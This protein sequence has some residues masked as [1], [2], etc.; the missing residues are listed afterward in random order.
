MRFGCIVKYFSLL[1]LL[2]PHIHYF[3]ANTVFMFIK[4]KKAVNQ[5]FN[6]LNPRPVT[7][8]FTKASSMLGVLLFLFGGGFSHALKAQKA[9]VAKVAAEILVSLDQAQ[10]MRELVS[11]KQTMESRVTEAKKNQLANLDP[12][13]LQ[14]FSNQYNAVALSF[15]ELLQALKQDVLSF[16]RKPDLNALSKKYQ[17]KIDNLRT[18]VDT[19]TQINLNG[20]A[21]DMLGNPP[22][23]WGQII[24]IV[25]S[26]VPSIIQSIQKNKKLNQ[27]DLV[28][29]INAL[30]PDFLQKYKMLGFEA[31]WPEA[32][33]FLRKQSSGNSTTERVAPSLLPSVGNAKVNVLV[34]EPYVL[35]PL[36]GDFRFTDRLP[37]GSEVEIP[38][39]IQQETKSQTI[40]TSA[41]VVIGDTYRLQLSS[42]QPFVYVFSRQMATGN[43]TLHF[44]K[45]ASVNPVSPAVAPGNPKPSIS[46]SMNMR[47]KRQMLELTKDIDS[48][49]K[50]AV[51]IKDIIERSKADYY[52]Y[53]SAPADNPITFTWS[54]D[55]KP[56]DEQMI[57]LFSNSEIF[58]PVEFLRRYLQLP[59]G[60]TSG[61]VLPSLAFGQDFVAN[62]GSKNQDTLDKLLKA[63]IISIPKTR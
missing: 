58:F 10:A 47:T 56:G 2:I 55:D 61:K 40:L 11:L 20:I 6:S 36:K 30:T 49:D 44:P 33:A 25:I 59:S 48:K 53:Q 5:P 26:A 54:V 32:E 16:G 31:I 7:G 15:N 45:M 13:Q 8:F 57:I 1:I 46:D 12:A 3:S 29:A 24:G 62:E 14:N 42:K 17:T 43:Y 9:D 27:G 22:I 41:P 34:S 52:V 19:F 63:Y 60:N 51:I 37:D 21:K 28:G 23:D 50:N 38:M 35:E 39:T 18:S 4:E